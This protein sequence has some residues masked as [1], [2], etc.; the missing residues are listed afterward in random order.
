MFVD[1]GDDKTENRIR[2]DL[3]QGLVCLDHAAFQVRARSPGRHGRMEASVTFT[4][5]SGD[6]QNGDWPVA[7]DCGPWTVERAVSC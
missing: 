1:Q 6:A 7:V 2:I 3:S 4:G 5:L